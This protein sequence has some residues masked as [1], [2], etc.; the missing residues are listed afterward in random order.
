MSNSATS[1]ELLPELKHV[2]QLKKLALESTG[3]FSGQSQ[4]LDFTLSNLNTL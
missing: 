1:V 4:E 3:I 2:K